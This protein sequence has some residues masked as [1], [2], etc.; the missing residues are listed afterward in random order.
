MAR[1]PAATA[2]VWHRWN[3][4]LVEAREGLPLC[5]SLANMR[6]FRNGPAPRET[7]H[8][9]ADLVDWA[10]QKKILTK[11]DAAAL[12]ARASAGPAAA[13]REFARAIALREAIARVFAAVAHR[14]RPPPADL[15]ALMADFDD[16]ARH[17]RLRYDA[18]RIVPGLAGTAPSLALPRWQAALSAVGLYAA[19]GSG[20]VREC[21]D[22]RGCGWLFVDA[23]KN[24][25]RRY[26][27]ANE[28]GNRA[29][30]MNFRARR[31]GDAPVA[32][33]PG[34]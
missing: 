25:S 26:C 1:P 8:G 33:A 23:T 14:R 10:L 24:G 11:K 27:F 12:V 34:R 9:Y 13:R 7:L 17:L 29:R 2:L 3:V 6:H 19:A 5:L 22:D 20:R 30:Q 18:G 15:V 21:A 32:P 28:C 31:R 4:D 16:A